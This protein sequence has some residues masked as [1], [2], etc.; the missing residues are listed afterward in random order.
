MYASTDDRRGDAATHAATT[1]GEDGPPL[2]APGSTPRLDGVRTWDGDIDPETRC[3]TTC[4]GKARSTVSPVWGVAMVLGAVSAAALLIAPHRASHLSP[5]TPLSGSAACGETDLR[6][7]RREAEQVVG[8]KR[9]L[10]SQRDEATNALGQWRSLRAEISD[11]RRALD[12]RVAHVHARA[13]N[14]RRA[15]DGWSREHG[16]LIPD[17]VEDAARELVTGVDVLSQTFEGAKAALGTAEDEIPAVIFHAHIA[18]TAGSTFNRF[19]ARRYHATCG[20][21]GMSFAQHFEDDSYNPQL[22]FAGR[23]GTRVIE[24]WGWHNCGLISLET[25]NYMLTEIANSKALAPQKTAVMIPCR[26]PIDHILSQCNHLNLSFTQIISGE[27]GAEA[28]ANAMPQCQVG[29]ERYEHSMLATFDRVVLFKYDNFP[30]VE[31]Y[32]DHALPNRRVPLEEG[33]HEEFGKFGFVR[34]NKDRDSE[35]E[36][37]TESC[38]EERLRNALL[39]HWSYYR[40]CDRFLGDSTWR[41]Y[42]SGD[43]RQKIAE[44]GV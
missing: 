19:A 28:C 42:D 36:Q 24:E 11:T 39:E 5:S 20:N 18:K 40:L 30:G 29:W 38:T 43:L 37:F 25:S 31:R 34:M 1:N 8:L 13:E 21:K 15:L 22:I 7:W 23:D 32:L 3:N 17:D 12:A 10:A 16:V 44:Q 14:V 41:E 33:E 4:L 35:S 9:Q 6:C 2:M 27:G 26:D